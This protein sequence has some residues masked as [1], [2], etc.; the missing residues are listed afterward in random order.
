MTIEDGTCVLDTS[1]FMGNDLYQVD[2][3]A[4]PDSD[5]FSTKQ[6]LGLKVFVNARR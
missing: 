4:E 3:T 1:M 6:L 2:W 5:P